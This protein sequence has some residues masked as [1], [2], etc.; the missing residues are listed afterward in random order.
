MAS[1]DDS[2][3]AAIEAALDR[4]RVMVRSVGL[5]RG[6]VEADLDEMIQ[7]VRIRLW[8]ASQGG[9]D[10]LELGSSYLYQV[11]TTAVLDLLRRRR[12]R[13][14]DRTEDV[15]DRPDLPAAD[16]L[17]S[18]QLEAQELAARIDGA[19]ESLPI[20][21]RVAV[22]FHLAGYDRQDV[23]RALGWSEA[24]TRNLLYRGLE[25]LRKRL[26]LLGVAP[27]GER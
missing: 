14:A 25:Q 24:R 16:P 18:E 1:D 17:P 26:V 4:F 11:A 6:L 12:A 8:R 10:L 21:R 15:A 2:T 9:K 13:A 3:S 5:R 22:R 27:I 7:E 20:D 23:A 19:V